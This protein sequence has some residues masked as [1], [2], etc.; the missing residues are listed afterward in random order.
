[1]SQLFTSGGEVSVL[2]VNSG[3]ISFNIDWFDL[4]GVQGALKS[5]LWYQN[6]KTSIL[7]L[8]N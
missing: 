5:L 3:L 4:L 2:P 8:K 6:S 7:F 1:M